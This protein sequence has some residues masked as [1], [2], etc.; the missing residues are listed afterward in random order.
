VLALLW[1]LAEGP[2]RTGQVVAAG[3]AAVGIIIIL[4]GLVLLALLV[5]V[6]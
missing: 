5:V 6:G 3:L 1:A 4:M 2:R